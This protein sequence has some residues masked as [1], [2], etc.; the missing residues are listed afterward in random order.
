MPWLVVALAANLLA[1]PSDSCDSLTAPDLATD[2]GSPPPLEPIP[3]I[4]PFNPGPELDLRT[5]EIFSAFALNSRDEQTQRQVLRSARHHGYTT[6][7]ICVELEKWNGIPVFAARGP[8]LAGQEAL[9]AY[10]RTLE[11]IADEGMSALVMGICTTLR[12]SGTDEKREEWAR[13]VGRRTKGH[14]NV[15]IE[16][17]N[18]ADHTGNV[19]SDSNMNRIMTVMRQSSDGLMVG[20]D[21]NLGARFTNTAR[22]RYDYRWHADFPSFHPWRNPDPDGNDIR[23]IVQENHGYAI[24][25][26][27]TSYTDDP[28]DLATFGWLVSTNRQQIQLYM[29][30]C[31]PGD[32]CVWTFHSIEGLFADGQFSWMPQ[33]GADHLLEPSGERG[34]TRPLVCW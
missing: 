3:D 31:N 5:A 2:G 15:A 17:V 1:C 18:E 6:A 10:E 32:G 25:S 34:T 7:R 22:Y 30:R 11:V 33:R 12:S 24:L 9:E 19:V 28:A 8:Y 16:A 27:T 4:P 14:H 20:S 26:E 29:N 23:D 13:E 21:Q